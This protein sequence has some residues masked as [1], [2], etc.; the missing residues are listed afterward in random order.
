MSQCRFAIRKVYIYIACVYNWWK[1]CYIRFKSSF[2][3][4]LIHGDWL[5]LNIRLDRSLTMDI[6]CHPNAI[7]SYRYDS[8]L[9]DG[10]FSPVVSTAGVSAGR[11]PRSHLIGIACWSIAVPMSP[12]I[13]DNPRLDPRSLPRRQNREEQRSPLIKPGWILRSIYLRIFSN[14]SPPAESRFVNFTDFQPRGG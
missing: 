10:T 9:R 11:R 3:R 14:D 2:L 1:E 4:T 12:L 7:S 8:P 13:N 5:T 6:R